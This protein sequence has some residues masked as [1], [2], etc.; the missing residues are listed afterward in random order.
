MEKLYNKELKV[1]EK[2]DIIFMKFCELLSD[3]REKIKK[4]GKHK[5]INSE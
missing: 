3:I 2:K 1:I 5:F 4:G